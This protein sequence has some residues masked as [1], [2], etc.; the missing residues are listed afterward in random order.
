MENNKSP[1]SLPIAIAGVLLLWLLYTLLYTRNADNQPGAFLEFVPGILAVALL[2]A[3]GLGW[4]D[5]YLRKAKLSR[6]GLGLLAASFVFVPLMLL[7]G[8]WT[9]GSWLAALVY[10]P[11]SGVSQELFFRAALLPVL[12][13]AFKGRPNLA[14]AVH[15]LLFVAWHI[16]KAFLAAAPL[17]GLIGISVVTFL[18]GLLW[19]KQVQRDGTVFWLMG[20]H[21]LILVINSFF[22]W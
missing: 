13:A 9:G 21:S 11:A 2:R 10:A 12:M 7:T 6:A 22:T 15:A 19:G 4:Q 18:C 17:G 8:R 1:L 20:Y 3:A 5:C 14:L 16:P